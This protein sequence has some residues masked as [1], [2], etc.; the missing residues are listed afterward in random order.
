[1][2]LSG[3]VVAAVL[4][5]S[6]S[7]SASHSGAGSGSSG[8]FS[9]SSSHANSGGYSTAGSSH[10]GSESS[11]SP[12]AAPSNGPSNSATASASSKPENRGFF[13]FF[14]H[15]KPAQPNQAELLIKPPLRCKKGQNCVPP[16]QAGLALNGFACV[17]QSTPYWWFN[18]C[19]VLANELAAQ[20]EQMRTGIDRGASLRYQMLLNQ[21]QQCMI[22]SRLVPFASYAF[23]DLSL[24]DVP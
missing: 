12:V 22:R 2:R 19:R 23:N 16:C 24:L 11:H 6:T 17:A 10:T 13:S 4:L 14:R 9:G 18:N 20:R 3:L 5:I 8:G 21:Y 1:M 15:R 7:L